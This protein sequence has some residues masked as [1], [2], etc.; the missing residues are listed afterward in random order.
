MTK[1]NTY[2]VERLLTEVELE[3]MSIVWSLGP[4]TVKDVSKQLPKARNL[5]YTTIATVM[6]ILENKGFLTCQKDTHAHVFTPAVSKTHYEAT[7]LEHMVNHV[8]DGEPMAL[9]QRLIEAKKIQP[10]D[11]EII[12]KILKKLKTEERSRK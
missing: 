10:D 11:I 6:K 4:T 12:E 7:C 2:A 3:L 9:V 8:F 1:K 5:A